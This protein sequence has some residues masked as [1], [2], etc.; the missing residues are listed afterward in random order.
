VREG[1]AARSLVG[2]A[3]TF[4]RDETS[5]G[6]RVR[7]NA[8]QIVRKSSNCSA[9]GIST[10]FENAALISTT[11][12]RCRKLVSLAIGDQGADPPARV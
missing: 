10:V 3:M 12:K 4:F 9:A 7:R 5:R 8:H 11:S 1:Y 2:G 6:L